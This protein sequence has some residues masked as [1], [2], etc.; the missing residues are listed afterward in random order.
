MIDDPLSDLHWRPDI[1]CFFSAKLTRWGPDGLVFLKGV[2]PP[3]EEAIRALAA[4]Y[5]EPRGREWHSLEGAALVSRVETLLSDLGISRDQV[6]LVLDNTETLARS[7]EDEQRLAA[8]IEAI[9]KRLARVLITSRRRERMEA[10]PVEVPPLS[11]EEGVSLI[12]RL[13]DIYHASAIQRAGSAG[14]RK[15]V[16]ALGGHPIKID[17]CCRLVGRYGHSLDRAKSQVLSNEDL[18]TFLYEDAWARVSDEQRLGLVT[19]A[20]FGD[21]LSGELIHFI[22]GELELDVSEV[23]SALEETKFAV[24]FDY[25]TKFDLRLEDSALPFLRS[26][27]DRLPNAAKERVQ[28]AS[29][30]ASQRRSELLSAQETAVSDRIS[31]AF[32]TDAAKAAWQAAARGQ[33]EDAVFW[34][35]EAVKADPANAQL[36]D[37]FAF[38]L[39]AKVRQIDRA[40]LIA[41]EAC[42][43]DPNFGDAFFTAGHIAASRADVASA[44]EHLDRARR[45]GVL[46][47]RCALQRARARLRSV[48]VEEEAVRGRP[49]N[50]TQRLRDV[51]ELLRAADLP[52]LGD[53]RDH[54]HQY[55]VNQVLRRSRAISKR[56]GLQSF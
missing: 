50:L 16:N 41:Q 18:G 12:G 8:S 27:F 43:L 45:L 4:S 6:L 14:R 35:E 51:E 46:P 40:W 5:D 11:L 17:A 36:L 25:S 29:A 55:E 26:A 39:A 37:R 3:I 42:D 34:Y 32:R 21:S 10:R 23:L 48:E 20:Q 13:A 1:I 15:L 49:L 22:C 2:A 47:H 53:E 31:D 44:D 54:K 9:T 38:F 52:S 56:F 33:L 7:A 30:K 28:S 19:L 24:R